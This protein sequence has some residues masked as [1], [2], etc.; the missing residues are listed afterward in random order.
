MIE[1]E[2]PV[3]PITTAHALGYQHGI[4]GG[5]NEPPQWMYKSFLA[6]AAYKRGKEQGTKMRVRNV[7]RRSE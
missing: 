3:N 4:D 5:A 7:L 2:K 1:E 6:L